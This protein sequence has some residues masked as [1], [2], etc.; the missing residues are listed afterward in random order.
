MSSC[1]VIIPARMEAT[2]LPGKPLADIHGKPMIVRVWEQAMAAEI[3]RVVVAADSEEILAAVRAAGGEGQ[4]TRTDHQSG[5]DR[6]F[7]ALSPNRP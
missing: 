5:S 3:G 2:R 1:I 4:I 7:E 6:A